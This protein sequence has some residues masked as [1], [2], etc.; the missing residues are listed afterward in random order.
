MNLTAVDSY[1]FRLFVAFS[2]LFCAIGGGR[3]YESA[4]AAA[5][6]LRK[7]PNWVKRT[8]ANITIPLMNVFEE[9]HCKKACEYYNRRIG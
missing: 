8:W 9:D 2:L 7:S 3:M 1:W 5:W 4:C 6:R